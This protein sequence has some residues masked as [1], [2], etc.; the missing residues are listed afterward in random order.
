MSGITQLTS[1]EREQLAQAHQ[2]WLAAG[3]SCEPLN[4]SAVADIM[5]E[6]Y[7]HISRPSPRVLYF[8]SPALALLAGEALAT[9]RGLWD[10]IRR[11]LTEPFARLWEQLPA[12]LESQLDRDTLQE[13]R[14]RSSVEVGLKG[15]IGRLRREASDETTKAIKLAMGADLYAPLADFLRGNRQMVWGQAWSRPADG[16]PYGLH[17]HLVEQIRQQGD[18]LK[19]T[20]SN[21]FAMDPWSTWETLHTFCG[22]LG[23][24]Y[25]ARQAVLLELCLRSARSLHFWSAHDGVVLCAGRPGPP[26]V[27]GQGRLHGP[28]LACA[29]RD[30]WGIGAW[31]GVSLP[32]KYYDP[33][34]YLILTEP[35][36][37]LRRMLMER[38]DA[39]HGKGRFVQD[40]GA[41]VIDSAVQPMRSGEPD[42]INELLSLD[43]PG[44]PDHVV[45]VLRV[46]DPSTGRVYIIR[47]PPD[48]RTVSNALAWTF[49]V[50]P[51]QYVLQQET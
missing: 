48:Q 16:A 45:V 21:S 20:F 31:R 15:A 13:A 26:L 22:W 29:Y 37:E 9:R 18:Y 47:V 38:Y 17:E 33:D 3:K 39:A 12:Q 10:R 30:G 35:N 50:E 32:V 27:D 46:V 8:S 51:G 40:A 43:L 49:D 23:V 41:K 11:K 36:A 5:A 1:A 24:Q 25:S 2:E 42:M 14:L 19:S 4:H 44:D 34:P 6:Y 28:G 7:Y